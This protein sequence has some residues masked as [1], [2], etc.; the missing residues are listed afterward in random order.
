MNG[1]MLGAKK[2]DGENTKETGIRNRRE[3]SEETTKQK[4]GDNVEL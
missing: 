4:R 3:R 2:L 1:E